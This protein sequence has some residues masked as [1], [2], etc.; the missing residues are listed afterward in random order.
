[1]LASVEPEARHL[2]C[3]MLLT[4]H[5]YTMLQKAIS[6]PHSQLICL[7]DS[8]VVEHILKSNVGVLVISFLIVVSSLRGAT[9]PEKVFHSEM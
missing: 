2:I 8:Q 6:P 3:F 7:S 9:I 4:L 1:M 5:Y